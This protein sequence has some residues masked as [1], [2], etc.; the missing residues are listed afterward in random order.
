MAFNLCDQSLRM[1][2]QF[3]WKG[4]KV[5]SP[6]TS[7]CSECSSTCT[8]MESVTGLIC[9]EWQR[10][11]GVLIIL[12]Y[13]SRT[14]WSVICFISRPWSDG[15]LMFPHQ[16]EQKR[17][18]IVLAEPPD[19]RPGPKVTGPKDIAARIWAKSDKAAI[20]GRR[21]TSSR[22]MTK[23]FNQPSPYIQVELL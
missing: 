3:L 18:W 2:W 16:S 15:R 21:G 8:C 9:S 12:F 5:I 23:N 22:Q 13:C 10:V 17:A 11:D 20:V 7:S 14:L 1:W 19:G 4:S 6:V